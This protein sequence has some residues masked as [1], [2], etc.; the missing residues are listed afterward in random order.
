MKGFL[1]LL[2]LA[3]LL[4]WCGQGRAADGPATQEA[5]APFERITQYDR[6]DSVLVGVHGT[7]E[8]IIR[9]AK[10][11]KGQ[12]IVFWAIAGNSGEV[13]SPHAAVIT[14]WY[15]R[16]SKTLV[17]ITTAGVATMRIGEAKPKWVWQKESLGPRYAIAADERTLAVSYAEIAGIQTEQGIALIDIVTGVVATTSVDNL[18]GKTFTYNLADGM[19]FYADNLY[20]SLPEGRTWKFAMQKG[21]KGAGWALA[22]D[23][24]R[25]AGEGRVV[26]VLGKGDLVREGDGWIAVGQARVSTGDAEVG[27]VCVSDTAVFVQMS[28]GVMWRLGA[29]GKV[30]STLKVPQKGLIG[31]GCD[32]IGVWLAYD[33]GL[34]ST[35]V[36]AWIPEKKN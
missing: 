16:P 9:R 25:I 7:K 28:S 12:S 8:P 23:P 17:I 30:E 6:V 20:V 26:G 27:A 22:G 24:E 29:N 13:T 5:L 11:I 4:P 36:A 31:S 19:A 18:G 1:P 35:P 14:A 32:R 33:N 3:L 10:A 21:E 2:L 34:I 15:A